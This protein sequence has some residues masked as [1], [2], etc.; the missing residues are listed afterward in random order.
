MCR[1][2]S[3]PFKDTPQPNSRGP[4]L[5]YTFSHQPLSLFQPKWPVFQ[6]VAFT[7]QLP[8]E[9]IPHV[10]NLI[11][12]HKCVQRKRLA[13]RQS[14][15]RKTISLEIK[16]QPPSPPPPHPPLLSPISTSS[17]RPGL[18]LCGSPALIRSSLTNVYNE[19][20]QYSRQLRGP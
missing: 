1:V 3:P 20:E 15:V 4:P 7:D 16:P 18:V 14:D 10:L 5:L 2:Y 17:L 6:P 9:Y 19:L 8:R 11:S 13:S 12:L